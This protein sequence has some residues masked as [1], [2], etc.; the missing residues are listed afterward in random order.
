VN[1]TYKV[2]CNDEVE[3]QSRSGAG[4]MDFLRDHQALVKITRQPS[5]DE[6]GEKEQEAGFFMNGERDLED[7][8]PRTHLKKDQ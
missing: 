5:M 6:S 1:G 7:S 8:E 4:Q 2:R 3:A